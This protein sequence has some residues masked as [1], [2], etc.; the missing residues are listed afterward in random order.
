MVK[1]IAYN[2]VFNMDRLCKSGILI[3]IFAENNYLVRQYIRE[4][5]GSPLQ[6]SCLENP[7]DWRS[8][9]GCSPWGREGQTRLSNFT[10]TSHF[11][12]LEKELAT[13]SSVLTWRIPRMGEPG[14]LLSMESQSRTRLKRL[15]RSSSK[16]VYMPTPCWLKHLC[17]IRALVPVSFFLSIPLSL[18]QA[19][20]LEHRGSLSSLP[21]LGF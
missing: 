18:F 20:P 3:F 6:Y 19:D 12:A 9:I 1:V 16:T 11:R 21:C 10:F 5:N 15:S 7:V 14:G 2:S 4:G 13:H 17:F 8:L